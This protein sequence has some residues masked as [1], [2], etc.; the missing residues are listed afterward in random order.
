MPENRPRPPA[1]AFTLVAFFRGYSI[2]IHA[3][4]SP[5]VPQ[6]CSPDPCEGNS[7]RPR[8]TDKSKI[9]NTKMESAAR[10]LI[11]HTTPH[12]TAAALTLTLLFLSYTEALCTNTTS[13]RTPF[14]S[15]SRFLPRRSLLP[16]VA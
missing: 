2:F 6:N 9:K 1:C 16:R 15:C 10:T 11:R 8:N 13:L 3:I 7:T 14:L 4:K 5:R 12:H